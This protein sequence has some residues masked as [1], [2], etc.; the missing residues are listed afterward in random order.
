MHDDYKD[1]AEKQNMSKE[2]KAKRDFFIRRYYLWHMLMSSFKKARNQ[3]TKP[4]LT[5]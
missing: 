5:I 4:F 3:K 2:S 1:M